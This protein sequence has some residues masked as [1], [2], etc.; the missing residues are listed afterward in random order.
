MTSPIETQPQDLPTGRGSADRK[1]VQ[2][3]G[4]SGAPARPSGARTR[5]HGLDALRGGALLLGI[6]LHALMPFLPQSTWMIVDSQ[7][8]ALAGPVV[9]VIHLFR[10]VLFMMLAGYFGSMVLRRRGARRYLG[11]RSK[12][13]LLPAIV[14]WP[15]S[16]MSTWLISAV[17]LQL[18]DLPPPPAAEN[19][20]LWLIFG[21]GVL[22]FLWTLM[23]ALLIVVLLR[24]LLLR[25]VG[26]DRL[27]RAARQ[28]G[29]LLSSP[30][31]VLLP[32]VPYAVGLILQ[33]TING[34]LR[35]PLTLIPEASSLVTYLGAFTTGWLLFAQP[36]SLQRLTGQWPAH[37]AA[38]L[39][40]TGVA[41]LAVEQ[42]FPLVLGAALLATAGWCWVYGLIGLCVHYL[43]RERPMVRYL[44]DSSYWAYLLH[45]PILLL[46]EMVLAELAWPMPVKLALTLVVTMTLLL[47]SY[48]LLVRPR[49]LGAWLNGRRYPT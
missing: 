43:R 48:H 17:N 32:A 25:I 5:L 37:L 18:R 24:V 47:S 36:G 16:V 33:G 3:P 14:F 19:A 31:A 27:G 40:G 29:R 42:E 34:G 11:D 26:A 46:C 20:S 12:R 49:A 15:V 39:V 21:P 44:A 8:S 1:P 28:L 41:Y 35:E 30:G 10:M 2:Q 45:L 22:W 7:P 23:E 38:A 9:F 13:I 4:T 6:V